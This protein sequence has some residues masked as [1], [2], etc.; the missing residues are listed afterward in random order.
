[1]FHHDQV[2][3][4]LLTVVG[5]A[6]IVGARGLP[7]VPGQPVGPAVFPIVIGA[8]LCFFGLLIALGFARTAPAGLVPGSS[9][10]DLT[11]RLITL[12]RIFTPPVLLLFYFLVVE[13]LGFLPTAIVLVLVTALTL[14]AKP[15]LAVPLAIVAPVLIH[16]IF[17]KLLRV[18]LP[19]GILPMPW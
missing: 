5:A 4:T 17:S 1:M 18:P 12:A 19:D 13:D 2:G 8:G 9:G 3:G 16:L 14:G 10:V 7:A 6:T 15:R 11:R